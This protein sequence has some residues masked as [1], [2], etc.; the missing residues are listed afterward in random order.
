[1]IRFSIR[2][3]LA[4]AAFVGAGMLLLPPIKTTFA[5]VGPIGDEPSA[6]V[7][8]SYDFVAAVDS[9]GSGASDSVSITVDWPQLALQFAALLFVLFV[10]VPSPTTERVGDSDFATD[11][12]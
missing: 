5:D 1:M 12:K 10:V 2:A 9:F 11:P 4:V 6:K 8:T 3:K 7:L